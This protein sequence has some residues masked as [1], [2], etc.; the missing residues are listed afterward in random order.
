MSELQ[1]GDWTVIADQ[2]MEVAGFTPDG[3]VIVRPLSPASEMAPI[4]LQASWAGEGVPLPPAPMESLPP[5]H[6]EWVGRDVDLIREAMR[7]AKQH[8][9]REII[10]GIPED[11]PEDP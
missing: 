2:I 11:E 7:L 1:V 10:F 4:G 5:I 3:I 9:Y 8:P 6:M